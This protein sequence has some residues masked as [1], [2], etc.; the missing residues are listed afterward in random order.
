MCWEKR[1]PKEQRQSSGRGDQNNFE[2]APDANRG[3]ASMPPCT[4]WEQGKTVQTGISF[5]RA[6]PGAARQALWAQSFHAR[7]ARRCATSLAHTVRSRPNF[8]GGKGSG[9]PGNTSVGALRSSL[10]H[11]VKDTD[12]S[13]HAIFPALLALALPGG[14]TPLAGINEIHSRAR[15]ARNTPADT[16]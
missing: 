2:N 8:I 12:G 1:L 5:R 13:P 16:D 9:W 3:V 4:S 6:A 15:H 14:L 7:N 11:V 10:E